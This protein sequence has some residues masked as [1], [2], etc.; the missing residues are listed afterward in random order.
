MLRKLLTTSPTDSFF[1]YISTLSRSAL[2]FNYFLPH[3][4]PHLS[5]G[6]SHYAFTFPHF[7]FSFLC[8]LSL[9]ACW[10]SLARALLSCRCSKRVLLSRG[11]HF[12]QWKMALHSR[13]SFKPSL[14]SRIVFSPFFVSSRENSRREVGQFSCL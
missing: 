9:P 8:S 11:L 6:H 4:L 5:Q 12:L 1:A 13:I 7:L 14:F 10:C 3:S 2:P